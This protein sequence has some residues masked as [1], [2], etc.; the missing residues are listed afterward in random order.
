MLIRL[1]LELLSTLPGLVTVLRERGLLDGS[2][3]SWSCSSSKTSLLFSKSELS[4]GSAGS[5][6]L[7]EEF[8]R[9]LMED[10]LGGKVVREL[11]LNADGGR[12]VGMALAPSFELLCMASEDGDL[13]VPGC[14][15]ETFLLR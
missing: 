12:G 2:D 7:P 15:A 9:A 10:I 11:L 5:S 4:S 13:I 1:P 3:V 8:N 6:I 14:G